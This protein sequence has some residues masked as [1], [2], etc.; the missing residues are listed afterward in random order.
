[1]CLLQKSERQHIPQRHPRRRFWRSNRSQFSVSGN[2]IKQAKENIHSAEVSL[3]N[4]RNR[5]WSTTNRTIKLCVIPIWVKKENKWS[6]KRFF[7]IWGRTGVGQM[8]PNK[9]QLL[10][11]FWFPGYIEFLY[12]LLGRSFFKNTSYFINWIYCL[13]YLHTTPVKTSQK[14]TYEN[15][16]LGNCIWKLHLSQFTEKPSSIAENESI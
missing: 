7:N 4:R 1:M 8:C 5:Q 14:K 11:I 16:C 6:H 2:L 9:T 15:Q 13:K 3:T 12:I 10:Q